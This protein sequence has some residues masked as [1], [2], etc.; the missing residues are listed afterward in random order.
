MSEKFI[1]IRETDIK[2]SEI[3]RISRN[4]YE[5]RIA[6]DKM[7]TVYRIN[8]SIGEERGEYFD[9]DSWGDMQEDRD[10]LLKACN[11]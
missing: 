11:E 9:Y 5:R 2:I 6:E 1:T 10:R 7:E 4:S 8:I 3:V